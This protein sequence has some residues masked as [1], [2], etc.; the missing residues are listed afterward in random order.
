MKKALVIGINEY[1]KAL[2]AGCVNDA[3]EVAQ[4]LRTNAD[5][6]INYDVR[7][8]LNVKSKGLLRGMIEDLF[9]GNTENVLLYFSGH[10]TISATGGYIVTPDYS[11]HDMGVSMDDIL[12]LANQS[13]CKN[14]VIILDCCHAGNLGLV[15]ATG[16]N[17]A[18]ICEGLTVLT[19]C[20]KKE[21]AVELRGH[22][23]FTALFIA[24]LNG[25]AADLMGEITPGSIYAY[26]DRALGSWDQRPMF[27]TNV[28]RFTSLRKVN[29]QISLDIL[30]R[31]T[32]FFS[33]EEDEFKLDPSFEDTNSLEITHEVIPPYANV[34][35]VKMFKALQKLQSA[36]L[37][38][39]VDEDY[40]YFAAMKSKA[41]AL[42]ALGQRYWKLVK[43]RRI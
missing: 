16:S 29:P 32:E 41:C 3:N 15:T 20:E 43:D 30:H 31:I 35:H 26:I 28:N 7:C 21:S 14:K 5:G 13:S 37:V 17:N 9:S 18:I 4:L 25:G 1:P 36:G 24:A 33:W 27:K 23:I 38:I 19:A 39:P 34:E 8:E 12:S 10:G 6:S 11:E 2:L 40:M 42:T 22:G